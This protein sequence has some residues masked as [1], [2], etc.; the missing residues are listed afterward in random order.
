M[1]KSKHQNMCAED[2]CKGD[3][4]DGLVGI[5]PLKVFSALFIFKGGC[6]ELGTAT[7][8]KHRTKN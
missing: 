6:H 2:I 3:F 1:K 5:S 8:N 7:P 4:A